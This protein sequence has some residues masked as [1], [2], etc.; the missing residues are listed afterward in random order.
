MQPDRSCLKC[1]T[2][3][4]AGHPID[5]YLAYP[6]DVSFQPARITNA[7]VSHCNLWDQGNDQAANDA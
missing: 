4:R 3:D 7:G 1:A 5:Q 2:A 6:L